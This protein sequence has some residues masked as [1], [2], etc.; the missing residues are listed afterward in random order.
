MPPV[1]GA[2]IKE[3][4]RRLREKGA[5]A[6]RS[7]LDAQVGRQAKVLMETNGL[8]RTEQFTVVKVAD[9]LPGRLIDVRI[10]GHDGERLIGS[11]LDVDQAA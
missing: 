2:I 11:S 5:T 7:Y 10:T 1:D 8:G 6:L 9:V 3:R 4:A